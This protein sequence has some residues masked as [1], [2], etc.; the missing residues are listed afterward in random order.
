[1]KTV[2]EFN[3]KLGTRVIGRFKVVNQQAKQAS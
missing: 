3:S 2:D 1:M